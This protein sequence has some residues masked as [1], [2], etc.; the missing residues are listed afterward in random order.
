MKGLDTEDITWE[1]G[2][3]PPRAP[4]PDADRREGHGAAVSHDR[5][6]TAAKGKDLGY[7]GQNTGVNP[8]LKVKDRV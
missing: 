1:R 8:Q 5:L 3:P 2:A 7:L 4:L 6:G